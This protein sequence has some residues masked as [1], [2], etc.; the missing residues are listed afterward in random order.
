M[1]YSK[2]WSI[3]DLGTNSLK[4]HE[5]CL[6]VAIL[7]ILAFILTKKLKKSNQ[8]YEKTIILLGTG[9]IGLGAILGFVYLKFFIIDTTDQRIH[10]ILNSKNVAIVEGTIS[11]FKSIRPLSK[12]GI[13]TQESF[14]VD[15]VNFSYSDEL[16]GRFNRF[17]KT[18]NGVFK[19]G[20]PVRITYGKG[21]NEILMV[22]I[23]K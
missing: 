20:L 12:R 3:A 22:E 10:K 15:S 21:K 6:Y 17:S 5:V 1:E 23:K 7:F 13:V 18:N 11:N 14:T 16:L 19:N 2:Y 4:S 9:I 8:D